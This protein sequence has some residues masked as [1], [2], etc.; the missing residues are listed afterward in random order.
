MRLK[1]EHLP[2]ALKGLAFLPS[3]SDAAGN[4]SNL[5]PWPTKLLMSGEGIK[6]DHPDVRPIFRHEHGILF[7]LVD[8]WLSSFLKLLFPA[9]A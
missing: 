1:K 5:S 4:G 7:K 2:W 8:V 6:A 9:L 3:K